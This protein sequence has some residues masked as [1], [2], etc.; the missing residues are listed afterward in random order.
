MPAEEAVG[1]RVARRLGSDI[2]LTP[3]AFV[4][5]GGLWLV[6]TPVVIDH[7]VYPWWSDVVAGA[8]L[9]A[10]SVAQV[11]RPGRSLLLSVAGALVGGWLIAAPF[12]LGYSE[13][14]GVAWNGL[15]VGV[16]VV[17]LSVVNGLTARPR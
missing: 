1:S 4:G 5:L 11:V 9:I 17:L 16:L 3:S 15:L 13:Q 8:L 2:V 14:H 12:V 6:I 7:G 10:L